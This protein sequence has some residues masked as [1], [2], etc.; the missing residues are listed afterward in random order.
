MNRILWLLVLL[1]GTVAAE[2]E[3][4]VGPTFLAQEF[5]HSGTIILT[6][7][8]A[9]K[10]DFSIGHISE[11]LVQTCPRLDCIQRIPRNL[12]FGVGRY[13]GGE[14]W[15][16]G[17]SGNYFG[18]VNRVSG[19]H[20]MVGVMVG[21]KLCDRLSVRV[22][23]YSNAGHQ[24]PDCACGEYCGCGYNLGQDAITLVYSFGARRTE[25][26]SLAA[27]LDGLLPL[28]HR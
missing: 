15:E 8:V 18:D 9:G 11:Q 2:T 23:H 16:F 27:R 4:E 6:E 10:Y 22:R 13:W 1:T 25:P 20:F 12:Y 19:A 5:A 24:S 14:R 7:R 21:Y 17:L 26:V 3:L 28:A